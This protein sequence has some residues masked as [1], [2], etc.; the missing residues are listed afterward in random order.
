MSGSRPATARTRAMRRE[1]LVMV[2]PRQIRAAPP[3][4]AQRLEQG[5]GVGEAVGLSLHEA[6]L[7]CLVGLFGVEQR[8]ITSIA[9]GQL[10]LGARERGLGGG[11][12]GGGG[13][14]GLGVRFER[15]QAV[16]DI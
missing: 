14:Q 6:D 1:S 12:G 5:G 16:G 13:L 3:A 11:G 2:G 7:G 9:V 4:A 8:R 15:R 10:A